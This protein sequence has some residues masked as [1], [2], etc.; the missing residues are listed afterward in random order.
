MFGVVDG[1][2]VKGSWGFEAGQSAVGDLFAWFTESCVPA[3]YHDEAIGRR[4]SLHELLTE[5]A[6]E[7][8]IGEH[9]LVAIDWHNGNRSILVDA[10]L[11]GVIVGQTLTTTPEDQYR[12]L[13]EATAF[14]FRTIIEAFTSNGVEITEVVAAGGLLKNKF[15]MQLY[16]DVTRKPLS[17]AVS[18]YAG[19]LGSAIHG[20]VAA[21]AYPDVPTAAAAMGKKIPNAYTPDE[22][23]AAEYDKL[24]AEYATL[25]DYFGRGENKVMYRLKD[26]KRDAA[27][28]RHG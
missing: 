24:Y 3:E 8:A 20:A 17:L 18:A 4:I 23:A 19:A 12:A 28:R 25:H 11:S 27:A 2:L 21:G 14:G 1:G 10:N 5:K 15:L 16:S 22:A 9:G 6:A 7:Q 13:L 26:I